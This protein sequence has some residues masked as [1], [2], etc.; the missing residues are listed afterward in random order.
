M[1]HDVKVYA[2]PSLKNT[3]DI[4][5]HDERWR[6]TFLLSRG[7]KMYLYVCR[8][9][10]LT[11][12]SGL[13]PN[14]SPIHPNNDQVRKGMTLWELQANS[15]YIVGFLTLVSPLRIN[16]S[17][18][19]KNV[20]GMS[21]MLS[22]LSSCAVETSIL[23]WEQLHLLKQISKTKQNL[24]HCWYVSEYSLNSSQVTGGSIVS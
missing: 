18:C 24:G 5:C 7:K 21:I 6:Q 3:S 1:R 11:S 16:A 2:T 13:C 15:I 12:P 4:H 20:A 19:V 14:P 17:S 22:L 10:P 9:Q 8:F 23:S